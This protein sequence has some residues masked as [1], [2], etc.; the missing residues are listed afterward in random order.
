MLDAQCA[1]DRAKFFIALPL[2]YSR[3]T[4]EASGAFYAAVLLGE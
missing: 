4:G 1:E 2:T 3:Q